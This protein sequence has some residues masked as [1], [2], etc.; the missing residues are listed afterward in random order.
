MA[1]T[2]K[3]ELNMEQFE[4]KEEIVS[5]NEEILPSSTVKDT[6]TVNINKDDI[7]I[8]NADIQGKLHNYS[9]K[10]TWILGLCTLGEPHAW[11]C[12][13]AHGLFLATNI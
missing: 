5:I 2:I 11:P 13:A 3:K 1:E 4:I 8:E 10:C 6:S 9:I 7:K 12:K